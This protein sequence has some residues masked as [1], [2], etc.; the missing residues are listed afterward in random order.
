MNNNAQSIARSSDQRQTL[1]SAVRHGWN[2]SYNAHQ[3]YA[4]VQHNNRLFRQAVQH[5]QW[6]SC[7]AADMRLQAG[8]TNAIYAAVWDQFRTEQDV[9]L[10]SAERV[11]KL[12]PSGPRIYSAIAISLRALRRMA[13]SPYSIFRPAT[14]ALFTLYLGR[15]K[16]D[17]GLVR[18]ARHTYTIALEKSHFVINSL[19]IDTDRSK[20]W[21]NAACLAIAFQ[22]FEVRQ[23]SCRDCVRGC[24]MLIMR[25]H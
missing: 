16:G 4:S 9:P 7:L 12:A 14:L 3:L 11:A 21:A 6:R 2:H 10:F 22:L 24:K 17:P 18:L 13:F 25:S 23:A 8:G 1:S 15:L 5:H 20:C 19:F